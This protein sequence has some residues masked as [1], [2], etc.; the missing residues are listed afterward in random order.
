[1]R[2]AHI[3]INWHTILHL[4]R[5][6]F[7]EE[8]GNLFLSLFNSH[9][10]TRSFSSRL[11]KLQNPQAEFCVCQGRAGGGASLRPTPSLGRS[12]FAPLLYFS[13]LLALQS[14]FHILFIGII[15]VSFQYYDQCVCVLWMLFRIYVHLFIVYV[16]HLYI[17]PGFS[18]RCAG[19][20][21]VK[22]YFMALFNRRFLLISVDSRHVKL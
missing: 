1:M 5:N 17:S 22:S 8:L 18:K 9:S 11:G 16:N 2:A 14:T 13:L 10:H 4:N 12:V 3:F 15:Y 20:L 6:T 21:L 7:W 19:P